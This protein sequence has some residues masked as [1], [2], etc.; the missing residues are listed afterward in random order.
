MALVHYSPIHNTLH[1]SQAKANRREEVSP[2]AKMGTRSDT[3]W[4]GTLASKSHGGGDLCFDHGLYGGGEDPAMAGPRQCGWGEF[5]NGSGFIHRCQARAGRD[6]RNL[7]TDLSR[8]FAT[9]RSWG[10]ILRTDRG[11]FRQ[12]RAP[13]EMD[14]LQRGFTR[15]RHTREPR[16]RTQED[17]SIACEADASYIMDPLAVVEHSDGVPGRRA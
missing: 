13:L 15:R 1:K 3:V 12:A 4:C 8:L 16:L 17:R 11:L 9:D 6:S 5:G 10:R 7:G 2:E 14:E